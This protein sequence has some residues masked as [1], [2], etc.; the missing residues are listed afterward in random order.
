MCVAASLDR[1]A[2]GVNRVES[3]LGVGGER[4]VE[5]T[6]VLDNAF[7]RLVRR[8]LEDRELVVPV[9]LDVP[10][11]AAGSFGFRT[12]SPGPSVAIQEPVRSCL[13]WRSSIGA[14]RSA[15][16]STKL[17]RALIAGGPLDPR[18]LGGCDP[19]VRS[20]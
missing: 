20:G 6:Q 18:G 14:R 2:R 5:G 10:L 9:E 3:V 17:T 16:G 1:V 11:W 12:L 13:L 7:A 4:A 15:A 19:K 8:V